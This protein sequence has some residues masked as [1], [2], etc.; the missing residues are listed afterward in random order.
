MDDLLANCWL[1]LIFKTIFSLREHYF[2]GVGGLKIRNALRKDYDGGWVGHIDQI[3]HYVVYGQPLIH[4]LKNC[5]QH[6]Y[7]F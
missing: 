4:V 6:S 7:A 1:R 5:R 2:K 3:E